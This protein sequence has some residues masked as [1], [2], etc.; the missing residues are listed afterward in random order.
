[1]IGSRSRCTPS[2]ETSGPP[3]VEVALRLLVA[4]VLPRLGHRQPAPA[5]AARRQ[6]AEQV[7]HREAHLLDALR[8]EDLEH[9]VRAVADVDLDLALVE[10][11]GAQLGAQAL[12]RRVLRRG[13]ERR[14]PGDHRTRVERVEETLLDD[15]VHLGA[16]AAQ[17]LL[18]H[19]L[20]R[21]LAQVADDRLDVAPDVADLGEL[22][23][24]DLQEG[25]LG[26]LGQAPGH[27]GLPDPG[28]A[29]HDDVLR[30]DLVAQL[31][32]HL[33][34]APAVA[35]CD[36]HR[37]LG[38]RLPDDVAVELRYDLARREA[39]LL[40]RT[41]GMLITA[42]LRSVRSRDADHRSVAFSSFT[43]C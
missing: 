5:R 24:L 21:E 11:S 13:L 27:L 39:E 4:Q 2:R 20:D 30:R 37:A 32:R 28:R 35:Q 6:V 31:C 42:V 1:M 40:A 34:A 36:R 43:G 7:L 25:G 38:V 29:D 22:R 18:A 19:L 41:H 33:L 9:R 23:G 8:R 12:P 17:L 14:T 3:G 26:H 16:H 15:A 10:L